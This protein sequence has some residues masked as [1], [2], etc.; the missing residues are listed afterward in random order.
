MAASV[1]AHQPQNLSFVDGK[2]VESESGNWQIK[3]LDYWESQEILAM[4]DSV[5]SVR[6]T[7]ELGLLKAPGVSAEEFLASPAAQYVHP[8]YQAIWVHTRGN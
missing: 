7:L 3:S 6:R 1:L 8:L 4:D 2:F 5:K